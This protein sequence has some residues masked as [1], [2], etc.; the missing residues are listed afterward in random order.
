MEIAGLKFPQGID[1]LSLVPNVPLGAESIKAK[2]VQVPLV[3]NQAFTFGADSK[4][5]LK[6]EGS[7]AVHVFNSADDPD[8]DKVLV[9]D[10]AET[11][12][13]FLAPQLALTEE[14]AWLKYALKA[15]VDGAA[16]ATLASAGFDVEANA[17]VIFGDYRRHTRARPVA[18]ALALDLAGGPRFATA[19]EHVRS[20][21]IGEAVSVRWLGKIKTRVE[22]S[23]S[24]VFAGPAL[25]L[26]ALTG[27]QGVIGINLTAAA[28][29]AFSLEISDD[30][31]VIFSRLSENE[32]RIGIRKGVSRG[33]GVEAGGGITAH[34]ADPKAAEAV[35]TSV[36]EG[37]LGSSLSEVDTILQSVNLDRLSGTQKKAAASLIKRVGLKEGASLKDL[38]DRVQS[39]R[40]R[41][42]DAIKTI[43]K[44][45]IELAFAY[46]YNR[47]DE[48]TS[49]LQATLNQSR[50][51]AHHAAL[52]RGNLDPLTVDLAANVSGVRLE[53]YLNEKTL[54]R[55]HSWGF[56]LGIGKW[57]DVGGT[58][59]KR[60]AK[61]ERRNIEGRLQ[62]SYL[63]ARGYKGRW[64]GESMSWHV[65]LK[66]DMK[67]FA[68]GERPLVGEFD[69]GLHLVW[70]ATQKSLSADEGEQWLDGGVLWRVL[71]EADLEDARLRLLPMVNRRCE[72]M[73]QMAIPNAAL[74]TMFPS[75]ASAKVGS[76]AAALAL[77]MPWQKGQ[78]SAA[79]RRELYAPLW[80]L[81]LDDPSRSAKELSQAAIRHFESRQLPE[82]GFAERRFDTLRPFTFAGLVDL[83]GDTHGAC[84]AF[85]RGIGMLQSAIAAS[86]PNDKTIDHAFEATN[87]LWTQSHHVRAVGAYLL[88]SAD[89]AGV[90]QTVNRTLTVKSGDDV[91]VLAP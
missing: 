44:T 2:L 51:D 54:T 6:P 43:A 50:L 7:L 35:L 56:T 31:L 84:A 82:L 90:L 20:L 69:F 70:I 52:I 18:E 28:Q 10:A 64:V 63:G 4:L 77:A 47:L 36:V 19:L 13:G 27:V 24:D 79:R 25:S 83:N 46:E 15:G 53:S 73:I 34:F 86:A 16:N 49:L 72:L 71:A 45:K 26:G 80:A 37:V 30:F 8:G 76:F 42:H 29:V 38:A 48:R 68:A 17:G 91:I 41:V 12:E 55:E 87:D 3:P 5:T 39:I 23:W 61:T 67:G 65:D 14:A 89:A 85:T 59:F 32:W 40:D 33:V 58:D 60:V 74:R 66:A 9:A 75:L 62:E 1:P 22:V 81:Y 11:P 21:S 78:T 57:V 88:E